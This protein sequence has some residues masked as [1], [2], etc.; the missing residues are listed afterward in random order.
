MAV[1]PWFSEPFD[2]FFASDFGRRFANNMGNRE[3]LERAWI[4]SGAMLT[5]ADIETV[6]AHPDV[7][8]RLVESQAYI[9]QQRA[10]Q[11]A[12][13][14]RIEAEQIRA[15]MLGWL[16]QGPREEQLKK[17]G[18]YPTIFPME[19]K[20]ERERLASMGHAALVEEVTRRREVRRVKN[21]SKEDYRAEVTIDRAGGNLPV[22]QPRM[23]ASLSQYE[24]IPAV[25]K[26]RHGLE[27][28]MSRKG[29]IELANR[30][31][32]SFRECVRRFGADSIN[33]ILSG[34]R[35]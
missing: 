32:F 21:L 13:R 7:V 26:T 1:A 20:K 4:A 2:A 33:D 29:L 34:R 35:A 3:V 6:A 31:A 5:A 24:T 27:V 11:Q 18:A 10:A 25:Y 28:E 9:A 15:E 19:V 12:E 17:A 14:E 23:Q 16:T 8:T 22:V 30:D